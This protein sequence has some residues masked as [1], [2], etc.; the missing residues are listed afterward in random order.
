[1]STVQLCGGDFTKQYL[2]F[3]FN[4]VSTLSSSLSN[5][6]QITLDIS[7]KVISLHVVESS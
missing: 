6:K 3:K 2:T 7:V 1:M 5:V 4:V